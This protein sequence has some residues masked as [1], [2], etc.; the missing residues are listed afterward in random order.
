MYWTPPNPPEGDRVVY[1]EGLY[2][3]AHGVSQMVVQPTGGVA[4]F[5]TGGS[6]LR[7]PTADDVL[8]NTLR[9]ITMFGFHNTLTSI[10]QVAEEAEQ[11]GLL[12]YTFDGSATLKGRPCLVITR[13]ITQPWQPDIPNR[14]RIFIDRELLLP[15]RLEGHA[16]DG[17]FMWQYEF[18]DIRLNPGLTAAD[19]TPKA[20]DISPPH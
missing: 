4:R 11:K 13:I 8:A 7:L 12:Q 10:L 2:P 17:A 16:S 20:N 3:D 6:V 9:P 15:V 1:V 19:F 14:M 18:D 5:L